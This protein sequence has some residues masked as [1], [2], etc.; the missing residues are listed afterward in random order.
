MKK[1]IVCTNCKG[2]GYFTVMTGDPNDYCGVIG[3]KCSVC[4]G[5]GALEVDMTIAD[6]IRS[7]S[8]EDLAVFWSEH[9][10]DF[11]I[12][13][14]ECGQFINDGTDI[15]DEWCAACVLAWLQKPV[16]ADVCSK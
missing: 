2:N 6:Y 12:S 10:D 4:D 8:D 3:K 11:C 5:A 14:P 1:L 9:Y 15:P 7:M 13:K 16:E